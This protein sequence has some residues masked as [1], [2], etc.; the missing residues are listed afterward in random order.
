MKVAVLQCRQRI[1]IKKEKAVK[2][3]G[4][5]LFLSAKIRKTRNLRKMNNENRITMIPPN[6]GFGRRYQTSDGRH[7]TSDDKAI[8][9]FPLKSEICNL[10][11]EIWFVRIICY[12][13]IV[14]QKNIFMR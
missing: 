6:D 13:K 11:S 10:T 14:V 1:I 8:L 9:S 4:Q 12:L 2:G 5:I 7:Q 3:C